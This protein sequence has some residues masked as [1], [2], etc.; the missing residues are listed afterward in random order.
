M[1]SIATSMLATCSTAQ[2]RTIGPDFKRR[3]TKGH[4]DETV[5]TMTTRN[6]P[7]AE[8]PSAENCISDLFFSPLTRY[9]KRP[10][11]AAA[12]SRIDHP[13]FCSTV[14][15]RSRN[16]GIHEPPGF[17]RNSPSMRPAAKSPLNFG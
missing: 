5:I 12:A 4:H 10:I 9:S 17:R 16:V 3:Q 13:Y 7:K 8:V 11:A 15:N 2:G 14:S 1:P 6:K